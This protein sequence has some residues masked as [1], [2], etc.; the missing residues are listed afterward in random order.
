MVVN[1]FRVLLLGVKF[2]DDKGVFYDSGKSDE[3]ENV[4][5]NYTENIEAVVRR[6][7]SK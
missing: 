1:K 2:L 3:I 4:D 6:C 5:E 7:S